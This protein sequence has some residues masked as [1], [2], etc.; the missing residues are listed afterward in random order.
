MPAVAHI[1]NGRALVGAAQLHGGESDLGASALLAGLVD[2]GLGLDLVPLDGLHGG[3]LLP[4]QR[5]EVG[6]LALRDDHLGCR[7]CG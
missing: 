1:E 4:E 3:E 5:G 2:R 6:R 7:I